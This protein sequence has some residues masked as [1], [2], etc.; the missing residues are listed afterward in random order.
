MDHHVG[1]GWIIRFEMNSKVM[2]T[3]HPFVHHKDIGFNLGALAGLEYH[4]TDG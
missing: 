3:I 4:R 2:R 1:I